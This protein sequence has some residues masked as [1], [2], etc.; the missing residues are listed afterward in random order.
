MNIQELIET[1]K[2]K[3]LPGL[4]EWVETFD[5]EIDEDGEKTLEPYD[6]VYSLAKRLEKG[7]CRED[8]YTNILFH[9]EQI[10]YSEIKIQL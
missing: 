10:N 1:N 5:W 8:D 2:Q 4:Y 3:I 7:E 9:I 6:E